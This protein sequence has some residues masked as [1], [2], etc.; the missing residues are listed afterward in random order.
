MANAI[1]NHEARELDAGGRG[2]LPRFADR[3]DAGRRLAALLED[4]RD[5]DPV[6][7]GLIRGGVVVA[8][9][10]ARAL[11][12]PLDVL[13]VRKIG[14]PWQPELAAG[15][16][17]EGDAVYP[18]ELEQL[19]SGEREDSELSGVMR[20]KRA[21]LLEKGERFRRGRPPL[22]LHGRTAIVVDDGVATGSTLCAALIAASRL[23]A[24]RVVAGVP[25]AS[26]EGADRAGAFC[27]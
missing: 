2:S 13:L 26:S 9:E 25:I 11:G 21:E 5:Q 17:A 8:D 19:A 4:L 18:P 22:E 6:V 27:D 12:A 10:V 1:A 7:L 24:E 16:I 15:A 20:S 14:Y 23:G 3:R